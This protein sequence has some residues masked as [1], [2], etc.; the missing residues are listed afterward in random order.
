MIVELF[1]PPGAGK[2]TFAM[3]LD[4]RLRERG[5][6]TKM[7]LS[8]RPGEDRSQFGLPHHNVSWHTFS[9]PLLRITRPILQLIVAKA[10]SNGDTSIR[11]LVAKLPKNHQVTALRMRQYLIRLSSA[12]REAQHSNSVAIFD[13]AYVQAIV[14]I[15]IASKQLEDGDIIDL[16]A[17][18]PRCDLAIR[19]EAPLGEVG[20]RLTARAQAIGRIGRFLES[21]SGAPI[22]WAQTCERVKTGLQ[23][24][25]RT[26]VDVHSTD[27]DTLLVEVER[28]CSKIEQIHCLEARK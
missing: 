24:Y 22:D 17:I 27:R 20:T 6:A 4:V 3:A 12:W 7:H 13:Q 16:I 18:T 11:S 23:R 1:G 14:S 28:I 15:L 10:A 26:A 5:N 25:G 8:L 21:K 9:D 2:T 19:V